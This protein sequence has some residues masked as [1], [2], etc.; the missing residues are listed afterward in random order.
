MVRKI[1]GLP[2]DKPFLL[3]KGLSKD[4][5]TALGL[6]TK[7]LHICQRC[8]TPIT[9][10]TEVVYVASE[11]QVMCVKCAERWLEYTRYYKED[12]GKEESNYKAMVQKLKDS[13]LWME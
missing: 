11:D 4:F 7:H 5:L 3:L 8:G 9:H 6:G 1:T 10:T 13:K 12:K 2:E